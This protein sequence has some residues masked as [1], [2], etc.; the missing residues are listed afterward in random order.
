MS[1]SKNSLSKNKSDNWPEKTAS[2]C[3]L[4]AKKDFEI[5]HNV[6]FRKIKKDDDLSDIPE[7]YHPNLATEGVI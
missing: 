4:I 7:I 6:Y 2:K 5:N 1:N 3:S